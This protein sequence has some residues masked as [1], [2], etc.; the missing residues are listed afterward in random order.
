MVVSL[1]LESV[2]IMVHRRTAAPEMVWELIGGVSV[3]AWDKLKGWAEDLRREHGCEKFDEWMEWLADHMTRHF[4][5]PGAEPA[6]RRYRDWSPR[7]VVPDLRFGVSRRGEAVLGG[8]EVSREP[9]AAC[10][11]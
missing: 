9:T 11:R 2:G 7:T 8:P 6:F 5:E 4:D 3:T 10:P 1:T